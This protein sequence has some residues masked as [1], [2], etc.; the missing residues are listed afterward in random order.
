MIRPVLAALLWFA[1]PAAASDWVYLGLKD[2][3]ETWSREIPESRLLGFRGESVVDV[4]SARLI[5]TMLDAQRAP[6]WVDLLSEHRVLE[7]GVDREVLYQ[8]YD[9]A[10][11]VADRDLVLLRT[12]RRDPSGRTTTIA[13]HS[14]EHAD[15]PLVDNVMRAKVDQTWFAFTDLADGRT[16]VEVEAFTDPMGIVPSWLVNLVQKTWARNSINALVRCAGGGAEPA[17]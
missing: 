11:P 7:R 8:R 3:V 10:W 14:I 4:P 12:T 15:A 5:P 6:E 13:I 1:G 9:M 16:K 17:P 2:N